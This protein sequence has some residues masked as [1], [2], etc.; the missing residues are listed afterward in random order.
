MRSSW[1]FWL[2]TTATNLAIAVLAATTIWLVGLSSFV[3]VQLPITLLAGSIGVWL[4][5]VQHQFEDTLLR[6]SLRAP[7]GCRADQI[8]C[9]FGAITRHAGMG[10]LGATQGS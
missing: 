7:S 1:H 2:S 9:S 8:F 6:S 3:L 10:V 5:Y 4:F